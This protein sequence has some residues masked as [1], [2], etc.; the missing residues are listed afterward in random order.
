LYVGLTN[1]QIKAYTFNDDYEVTDTQTIATLTGV[2]NPN[3]TGIAFNPFENT[4]GQPRI[5]VAHNL[6]YANADSYAKEGGFNEL[7]DFSPYSG[8][9]SVLEGPDFSELIPVVENIGVSNHDHGVNGLAFDGNGD[10]LINV[11]SNTNAGIAD[12]A[13]GGID[14]SPFTAAILKAEITKPDFNGNIQYQLP[15]DWVAPE[16]LEITNPEESQGFGG[17]VSVAPGVDV[18]VYA[19]GLRNPYDLVYTTR[20]II[21]A[22]ENGANAGFGDVSLDAETQEPFS[23]NR[24]V[25]DELNI[26][27]ENNYYG[28]PNRNRGKDDPRQNTY[29]DEN[30]PSSAEH[31]APIAKFASST[32]GVA[33]YRSTTFGGQLRGNLLAQKWNDVLYN[34]EL[35]ED[36]SNAV[37]VSPLKVEPGSDQN[38]AGGLDILTGFGGAIVSIDH[39]DK[40]VYVS[41]PVVDQITAMVAYEISDWRAPATGGGQFTIGGLNFSGSIADTTVTIGGKN[42][43]ITDV[44]EKRIKG[45]FPAF[46]LSE[47]IFG[48]A[49]YTEDKLLDIT[50]NSNN[51]IAII[52]DAFQPLFV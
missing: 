27:E 5:Y 43:T 8:Q 21:Y 45:T 4:G 19:A 42:A 9:V 34:V 2:S 1:G 39:S 24:I 13:I 31:T 52:D 12:D 46:E 28:Q 41:T 26:I 47:P 50:V 38:V 22:T 17:I 51:E 25:H 3:I 15:A 6:F 49:E 36:G 30:D 18:S 32:N 14:E 37:N 16:G 44:S 40:S 10:L 35:S 11:G 20:G 33:E 23:A 7:T 29:Y 48:S